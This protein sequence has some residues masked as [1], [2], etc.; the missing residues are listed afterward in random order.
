MSILLPNGIPAREIL[1]KEG[2]SL[3]GEN[4][5]MLPK[6][7]RLQI[8]IVNLM[9]TKEVTETQLCRLLGGTELPV[10]VTFVKMASH[11]SKNTSDEH[12]EKFYVPFSAIADQYFDGVIITGAPIEHLEFTEVD[13]WDELC[14]VMEWTKT[15]ARTTLH[16]CWGAQAGLYYHHGI[17]KKAL[18]SKM[19][20]I[21]KHRVETADS[22]LFKGFPDTFY[23]P[24][25]RHTTVERA[26][27]EKCPAIQILASSD[28]AGVYACREDE[29]FRFYLTGHSEY[30]ARTLEKEYL[31]DKNLGLSIAVPE[32]Y[33]PNDDDTQEPP[34][35]WRESARI[36]FGNWVREFVA[37]APEK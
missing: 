33:Y 11:H 16:I 26:E 10:E 3:L 5:P 25:S 28:K 6:E 35:V 13:Y 8:A 24:H 18:D 32:N 4:T 29:C 2:V 23:I 14:E 30:D 37:K 34:L 17:P 12:M 9:P 27:I 7:E 1:S 36:L 21:F 15:H 31:R 20:G 19:F 22:K